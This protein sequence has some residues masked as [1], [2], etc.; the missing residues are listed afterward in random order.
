M[1][2]QAADGV[3][4][5]LRALNST[6]APQPGQG[7]GTLRGVEVAIRVGPT[8]LMGLVFNEAFLAS[9][10]YASEALGYCFNS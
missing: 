8:A 9:D 6:G 4:R 1:L 2:A 7:R 5:G 10:A 3:V